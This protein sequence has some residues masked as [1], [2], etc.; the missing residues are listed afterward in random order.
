MIG[1]ISQH[2][3]HIPEKEYLIRIIG[4]PNPKTPIGDLTF[5]IKRTLLRPK[6]ENERVT[7]HGTI[8]NNQRMLDT[9]TAKCQRAGSWQRETRKTVRHYLG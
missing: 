2:E 9:G 8:S 4:Q 6:P 3:K 5:G 7:F 1:E